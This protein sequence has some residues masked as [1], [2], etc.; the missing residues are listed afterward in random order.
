MAKSDVAKKE[1]AGKQA[2]TKAGTGPGVEVE[3]KP[4]VKVVRPPKKASDCRRYMRS[5]I[6]TAFEE[7]ANGFVKRA[8]AGSCAHLKLATELLDQAAV[9]AAAKKRGP[10]ERMLEKLTERRQARLAGLERTHGA[11]G[12]FVSTK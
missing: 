1:G 8:K 3:V 5:R 6:T 10:A 2:A 4:M 12:T 7:I 11:D 9:E